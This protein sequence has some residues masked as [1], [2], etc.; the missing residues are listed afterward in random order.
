MR[1]LQYRRWTLNIG[2]KF[3]SDAGWPDRKEGAPG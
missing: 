2:D 1:T 3:N